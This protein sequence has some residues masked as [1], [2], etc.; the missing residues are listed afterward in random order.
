MALTD[1]RPGR[2]STRRS[3]TFGMVR[4]L[5]HQHMAV[6]C[7]RA[8]LIRITILPRT[9][10]TP[11]SPHLTARTPIHMERLCIPFQ[12]TLRAHRLTPRAC[13]SAISVAQRRLHLHPQTDTARSRGIKGRSRRSGRA[14]SSG[15]LAGSNP[16]S[17]HL[18]VMMISFTCHV[19]CHG[20]CTCTF[21]LYKIHWRPLTMDKG[22]N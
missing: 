10:S 2:R 12:P 6:K 5:H 16:D 7:N 1:S 9:P 11:Q 14:G 22:M 4:R 20:H 3:R 21:I 13:R 17:R 8:H 18:G 15:G 19:M